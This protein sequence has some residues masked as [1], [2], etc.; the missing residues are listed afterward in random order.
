MDL[1]FNNRNF[2][3]L[4]LSQLVS[5]VGNRMFQIALLWWII[6]QDPNNS[7]KYA[8]A[9]LV[10]G[11]IPP[12]IFLNIIGKLIDRHSPLRI[13][14]PGGIAG[15]VFSV[16]LALLT[17]TKIDLLP[18]LF[19]SVFI[20]GT[21][22]AFIEPTLMKM[23]PYVA[24]KEQ[25]TEA[26]AYLSSTQTLAF[27][28]GA[29]IGAILVEQVGI[30]GIVLLNGA[31]FFISLLSYRAIKIDEDPSPAGTEVSAKGESTL[32]VL[33]GLPLIRNL[34]LGF[35]AMNMFGTPILVVLPLYTKNILQQTASMLGIFEGCIWLGIF[36]GSII[37]SR[38]VVERTLLF[39]AGNVLVFGIMIALPGAFINPWFY[40]FC[41][42][43]MGTS[44]GLLNVKIVSYFQDEIEN[45]KKGRFFSLLRAVTM[46]A[47]PI[48]FTVFGFLADQIHL[49]TL[50]LVQGIGVIAM[51]TLFAFLAKNE[52]AKKGVSS[53]GGVA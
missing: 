51:S 11:V 44:L 40:G 25:T 10:L 4:W 6:G 2:A 8:A 14:A 37:A 31:A 5:Q 33:K 3:F 48:G 35:G 21:I 43:G 45:E 29:V 28:T 13:L 1:I 52:Q 46:A 19:A 15:T 36:S 24:P 32:S 38:L 39:V 49:T 23:V 34:L 41:L 50:C 9:L 26:V 22:Q 27:F 12:I 17:L 42:Y 47:M 30:L 53:I 18:V 7:G 20:F 16:V